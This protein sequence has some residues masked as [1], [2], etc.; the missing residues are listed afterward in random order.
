MST[1]RENFN[2]H[3]EVDVD[4]GERALKNW[5]M[6]QLLTK[7]LE[8]GSDSPFN[9]RAPCRL[10]RPLQ[11]STVGDPRTWARTTFL[12]RMV[13]KIIK[14][15]LPSRG[16]NHAA[17][18][19]GVESLA[20]QGRAKHLGML[21]ADHLLRMLLVHLLL[22]RLVGPAWQLSMRLQQPTS[23][24]VWSVSLLMVRTSHVRKLQRLLARGTTC[25]TWEARRL[26]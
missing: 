4:F 23:Q 8:P 21:A 22:L 25:R 14:L 26:R 1:H 6:A 10:T 19:Q 2:S 18:S 7:I 16:A 20:H 9:P 13:K 15:E 5:L 17:G 12:A 11:I 3:S 24:A